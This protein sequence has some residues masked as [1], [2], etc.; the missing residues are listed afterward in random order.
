MLPRDAIDGPE[1]RGWL[2]QASVDR[3]RG[4]SRRDDVGTGAADRAAATNARANLLR[5]DMMCRQRRVSAWL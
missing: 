5:A 4:A 2:T 3:T 1:T